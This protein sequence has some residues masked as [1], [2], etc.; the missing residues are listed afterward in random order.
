MARLVVVVHVSRSFVKIDAV[1]SKE[2]PVAG[3][4]IWRQLPA[5]WEGAVLRVVHTDENNVLHCSKI[6][7]ELLSKL[8]LRQYDA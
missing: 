1:R 3:R 6:E 8:G 2:A 5:I 7:P 4:A